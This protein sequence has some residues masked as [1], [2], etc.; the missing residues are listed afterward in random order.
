MWNP[1]LNP[2]ADNDYESG[3]GLDV[4]E[5][6]MVNRKELGDGKVEW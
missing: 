3:D 4:D 6:S 5:M 2:T 1:F